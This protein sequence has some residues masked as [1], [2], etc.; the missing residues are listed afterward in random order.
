MISYIYYN[1]IRTWKGIANIKLKTFSFSFFLLGGNE[2]SCYN[3][4]SLTTFLFSFFFWVF[5]LEFVLDVYFVRIYGL[6]YR[7][8]AI[9]LSCMHFLIC[10]LSTCF[11]S[12]LIQIFWNFFEVKCYW[13]K[14]CSNYII[15]SL[16]IVKE[17]ILKKIRFF[18]IFIL[19]SCLFVAIF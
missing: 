8:C 13:V 18:E 2:L 16:V 9:V 4:S 1:W 10:T 6:M 14:H 12:W 11:Q 19:K 7:L 5:W 3:M 15:I 17:I